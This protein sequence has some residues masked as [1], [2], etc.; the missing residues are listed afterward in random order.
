MKIISGTC[1]FQIP[2]QT[3][4]SIG[5]FD[6]AHK[7]HLYIVKRMR[8]YIRRG[9]KLCILTFDI[10]PSSLG[11]GSDHGVFYTN[12]EKRMIFTDLEVD[13]Y[14]EFPFYEKTA[15]ISAQRFIEEYIVDKMNAKAV[16]VGQDCTFGQGA[17]GNAQMLRDFG[18]I[19]DYEVEIINRIRDGKRDISSTYLKELVEKGKMKKV[20]DLAYHPYFIRGRFRRD[21]VKVGSSIWYYVM[22]I[23][24][25]K[26]MPLGGVY[27]SRALYEDEAYSAMTNVNSEDRTVET[28]IYGGARGIVRNEVAIELLEYKREEIKFYKVSDLNRKIKE[29]IFEGQKWHKEN[30]VYKRRAL[31]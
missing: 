21:P 19:Y 15:S 9:Y 5:K 26:V 3:V 25:E 8:D 18:P 23:P 16:V 22:D 10:P 6:G 31:W 27:Y 7:G 4:V 13:Y 30:V 1:E 17:A 24:E 29:D 28:Y 14:I 20:R 2:E 11:F 12:K